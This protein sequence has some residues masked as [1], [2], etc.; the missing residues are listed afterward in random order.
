MAFTLFRDRSKLLGS[1][2]ASF[3]K[4]VNRRI[5]GTIECNQRFYISII[6]NTFSL[7]GAL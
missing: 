6:F 3:V 2:F 4:I 7:N 5:D 1:E